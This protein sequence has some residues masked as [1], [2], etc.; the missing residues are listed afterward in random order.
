MKIFVLVFGGLGTI[1]LAIAGV[2]YIREQ[3]FFVQY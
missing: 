2:V 3:S 1:L